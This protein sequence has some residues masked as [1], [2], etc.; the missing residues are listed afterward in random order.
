MIT[1]FEGFNNSAVK[2]T[3]LFVLIIHILPQ[4]GT[5]KDAQ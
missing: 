5:F 3:V 2:D 4:N 1:P